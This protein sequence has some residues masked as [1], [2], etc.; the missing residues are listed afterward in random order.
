M[1]TPLAMEVQFP[2]CHPMK[3]GR[4]CW[5]VTQ[6]CQNGHYAH[7]ITEL[8]FEFLVTEQFM[9]NL[10]IENSFGFFGGLFCWGGL[11]LFF[12][13]FHTVRLTLRFAMTES[14]QKHIWRTFFLEMETL[15][16]VRCYRSFIKLIPIKYC[17]LKDSAMF[18][19]IN[20]NSTRLF[21]SI[22]SNACDWG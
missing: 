16:K 15:W 10:T 20:L 2:P 13:L 14:E 19:L 17:L 5:R 21:N 3:I 11:G 22:H 9:W 4:G 8:E 7:L 18:I 6:D 12:S 1:L